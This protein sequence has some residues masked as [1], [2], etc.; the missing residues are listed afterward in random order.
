LTRDANST[1]IPNIIYAGAWGSAAQKQIKD[2]YLARRKFLLTEL[3]LGRLPHISTDGDGT[4]TFKTVTKVENTRSIGSLIDKYF[5]RQMVKA[6]KKLGGYFEINTARTGLVPGPSAVGTEGPKF[7]DANGNWVNPRSPNE[8]S[9]ILHEFGI[10]H[11][12]DPESQELFDTLIINGLSGGVKHDP[13][14]PLKIQEATLNYGKFID[15]L[16]QISLPDASKGFLNK[17]EEI[18][19]NS[20]EAKP[21]RVLEYKSIPRIFVDH[22][23]FTVKDYIRYISLVER[24]REDKTSDFEFFSR[25]NSSGIQLPTEYYDI[26]NP[27]ATEKELTNKIRN[28]M[29]A[30]LTPHAFDSDNIIREDKKLEFY[31]TLSKFCNSPEAQE[32]A[33]TNLGIPRG[34]SLFTVNGKSVEGLDFSDKKFFEKY[35]KG[36]VQFNQDLKDNGKKPANPKHIL[37]NVIDNHPQ[38]YIE[39][40][41]NTN[42]AEVLPDIEQVMQLGKTVIGAG[43][44]PGSDAVML[45]Q[46]I[47]LGGAGFVV[48]G[49]MS[50]ADVANKIVEEL[51][52]KKNQWHEFAL[53]E[54]PKGKDANGKD[55]PS[56]YKLNSTGEIKAKKDWAKFFENKYK[57]KMFHC[58]NIHENNAFNAAIFSEIFEG[59][60]AFSLEFDPDKH[61]WAQDVLAQTNSKSLVTPIS[62][63]NEAALKGQAY[64][65]PILEKYPFL[66]ITGIKN[67][68]DPNKAGKTFDT[69]L[70]WISKTLIGIAPLEIIADTVGL[71]SVASVARNLQKYAYAVNT[72]AS[73]I[74]RGLTQSAHKFYWQFFGEVFGFVSSF[75]PDKSIYRGIFRALNQMV[76]IGRANELA[77]RDNYNLDD[78]TPEAKKEVEN[79][80]KGDKAAIY[81]DKRVAAAN[82]NKE[83]MQQIHDWSH[84]KFGGILGKIPFGNVVVASVA[85]F[86]QAAKLAIDFIKIPELRRSTFGNFFSWGQKGLAKN[87]KNSGKQYGEVHEKNTYAFAGMA[88]L[89]AVVSATATD[90]L[91]G[92]SSVGKFISTALTN[93]ANM[94]PALGVVTAGKLVEQDQAGDP[95]LFTDIAKNQQVY[96]PEYSGLMQK[97]AGWGLAI[98]GSFQHTNTGQVLYNLANGLYFEGM[99]GQLKVSIDDA[100]VNN[101]TRW[102]QYY[103]SHLENGNGKKRSPAE[104]LAKAA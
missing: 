8:I 21:L 37:V 4:C 39:M 73:G 64:E 88:T 52:T 6:V 16:N 82:Y 95:R 32:W 49:L 87:S 54:I 61:S 36:L 84:E 86:N 15:A 45:A 28:G 98:F 26:S 56:D 12:D 85:Q 53:T 2:N 10:H 22:P 38:P 74:G 78:F 19:A 80:Y 76:L 75:L 18:V 58:N 11:L 31:Q 63:A 59:D 44:S 65:K 94:I 1:P 70:N 72:V 13:R 66:N 69:M 60:K 79:L 48:R 62:E 93:A 55:L 103:V 67:I 42:K 99:R 104:N 9:G 7:K 91:F 102:N 57:D 43:D 29:L 77:M 27:P 101:K 50:D 41:P 34:T 92:K 3:E 24:S 81:K 68:F 90:L 47:I 97:L 100:A 17:I 46:A 96:S 89:G 14:A 20:K 51:A 83:M 23:N 33:E 71:K 25:L 5:L 40:A 35:P 30:C